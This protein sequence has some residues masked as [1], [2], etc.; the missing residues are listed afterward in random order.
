VTPPASVNLT[1]LVS[2]LSSTWPRRSGSPTQAGGK[3]AGFLQFQ[4]QALGAGPVGDQLECVPSTAAE[5]H[6]A[7]LDLQLAGI[8]LGEIEDFVDDAE[9]LVARGEDLLEGVARLFGILVIALADVGKPSTPFMGVRISWLM[10]ARNSL[11]ARARFSAATS[12][13]S[14]ACAA[15]RWCS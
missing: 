10:L 1:A 11:R 7:A 3:F 14:R 8:D 5:N 15:A 2:R 4:V 6:F 9:Q 13:C 12:A